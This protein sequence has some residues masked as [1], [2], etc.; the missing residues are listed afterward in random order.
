[1]L[2]APTTRTQLPDV[3]VTARPVSV[4]PGLAAEL[5]AVLPL[6]APG[7]LATEP[8]ARPAAADA[9]ASRSGPGWPRGVALHG[10]VWTSEFMPLNGAIQFGPPRLYAIISASADP[11]GRQTSWA[12]GAG[13]G[14]TGRAW[15]RFTPRLEVLQWVVD[16][17]QER[18]PGWLT[19]LRPS[20]GWQLREGRRWQLVGAPTL[21]LAVARPEPGRWSLG[22]NQ[23]L[24][25]D[26]DRDQP[27][28]RLWPGVQ[29]GLR[30]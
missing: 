1:M 4:Q 10:E 20:V 6:A 3:A 12:L 25:L 18:A 16:T 27:R 17:D 15:G 2:R 11:V 14:T 21:N 7:A 24:W 22:Q 13:V 26:A 8:P 23:W 28:L 9:P 29:V 5:P 19:Q 30:F